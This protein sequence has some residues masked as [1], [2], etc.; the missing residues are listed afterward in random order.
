MAHEISLV[1]SAGSFG[2]VVGFLTSYS[3]RAYVSHLQW[4]RRHLWGVTP[5]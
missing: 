5:V 1:V 2:L 3:V 4:K